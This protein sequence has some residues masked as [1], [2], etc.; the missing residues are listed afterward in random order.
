MPR[1][2]ETTVQWIQKDETTFDLDDMERKERWQYYTSSFV[3]IEPTEGVNRGLLH[4]SVLT[5]NLPSG[6][7]DSEEGTVQRK[8]L[9]WSEDL[10]LRICVNSSR[11]IFKEPGSEFFIYT[12]KPLTW[13]SE[14][15][16]ATARVRLEKAEETRNER[17]K[18]KWVNMSPWMKNLPLDQVQK[19]SAETRKWIADGVLPGS[20]TASEDAQMVE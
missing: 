15:N 13:D 12:D 7:M 10:T 17:F 6:D 16:M 18:R 8:P 4:K 20:A 14:R 2:S 1:K 19:I 3:R 11:I 9:V 5:R